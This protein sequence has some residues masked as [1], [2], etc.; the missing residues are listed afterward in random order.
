MFKKTI[1]FKDFNGVEQEK[2]FYFHLSKA[3]LAALSTQGKTLQ[4]RMREIEQTNDG[5]AALEQFRWLIKIAC[6]I[7]SS[8]GARFIKTPEAQSELLD[9]P[10]FDELLME[11]ITGDQ[12]AQF[13]NQ[14]IPTDMLKEMTEQAEKATKGNQAPDP[15]KEPEDSRPAYQKEHRQP[16]SAELQKM[17]QQ[18]LREAWA[19]KE[20]QNK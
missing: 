13:I 11:L 8:D 12:G 1:K 9:S 4:D 14:L 19:W 15:F 16:T 6:G 20:T 5:M 7:R 2:D 3:D 18:E 17:N 10:A